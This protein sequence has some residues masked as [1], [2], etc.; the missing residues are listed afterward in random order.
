MGTGA[1]REKEKVM[2]VKS[3]IRGGGRICGGGG[4]GGIYKPGGGPGGVTYIA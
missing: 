1:N 3:K 2:K 4:G